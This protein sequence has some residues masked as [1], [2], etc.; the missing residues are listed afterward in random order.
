[1]IRTGF[2]LAGAVAS[3]AL[4]APAA[5]AADSAAGAATVNFTAAAMGEKS[6][7]PTPDDMICQ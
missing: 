4:I 3:L 6:V 1:M 2:A 5:M 7:V